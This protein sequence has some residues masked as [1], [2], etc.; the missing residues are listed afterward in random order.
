MLT[1]FYI[2]PCRDHFFISQHLS[3]FKNILSFK[4]NNSL[5]KLIYVEWRFYCILF[6]INSIH[7]GLS[8]SNYELV[9]I[10][11]KDTTGNE[12]NYHFVCINGR[13]SLHLYKWKGKKCIWH[14]DKNLHHI[15]LLWP[16]YVEKKKG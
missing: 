2:S 10:L 4:I 8:Y 15:L 3:L 6:H 9:C 12:R 14:L 13:T 11:S 7:S 5:G 1:L 16:T